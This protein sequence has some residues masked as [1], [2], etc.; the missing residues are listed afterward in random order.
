MA[1]RLCCCVVASALRP[2]GRAEAGAAGCEVRNRVPNRVP[3]LGKYDRRQAGVTRVNLA[4]HGPIRP[5]YSKTSNPNVA[6][7][8]PAGGAR[9][10]RRPWSVLVRWSGAPRKNDAGGEDPGEE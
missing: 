6:G 1:G 10:R 5:Q 3:R 4:V 8:N 7:S 2:V 9:E